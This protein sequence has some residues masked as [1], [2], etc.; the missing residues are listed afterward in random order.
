MSVPERPEGGDRRA[1]PEG[2]LTG[3]RHRVSA[4][5]WVLGGAGLAFLAFGVLVYVTSRDPARTALLVP[6]PWLAGRLWFGGAAE[7]LPSLAHVAG[8]ALLTAAAL[9]GRGVW[10]YVGCAAW[11]AFDI[12][13]EIGQL[14]G[15]D[16][17]FADAVLERAGDLPGAQAVANYFLAGT[18]DWADI[19]AA[20]GGAVVAAVILRAWSAYE[21]LGSGDDA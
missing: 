17:A 2:G 15:T 14:P 21:R 11:A 10:P 8:F 3:W 1:H 12:A 6:V 9:P 20:L 4:R 13:A 5:A 19:G 7:W 18:F 16:R